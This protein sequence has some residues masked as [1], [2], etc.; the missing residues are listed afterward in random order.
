LSLFDIHTGV[1]DFPIDY[2]LMNPDSSYMTDRSKGKS[3]HDS[4][5]ETGNLLHSICVSEV[6]ECYKALADLGTRRQIISFKA[7][8]V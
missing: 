1:D 4:Q 5:I 2:D 8:T 6:V 7:F 3:C